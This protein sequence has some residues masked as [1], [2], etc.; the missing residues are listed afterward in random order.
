MASD[1]EESSVHT[2]MALPMMDNGQ[3]DYFMVKALLNSQMVTHTWEIGR[4]A[5]GMV[6]EL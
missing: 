6:K 1:M 3:M 5:K 4:T 2:M